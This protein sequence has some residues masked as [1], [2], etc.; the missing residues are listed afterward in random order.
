VRHA[1]AG[2][3]SRRTSAGEDGWKGRECSAWKPALDTLIARIEAG[4]CRHRINTWDAV[5]EVIGYGCFANGIT[6]MWP[7][8]FRKTNGRAPNRFRYY[9]EPSRLENPHGDLVDEYQEP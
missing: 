4:A 3:C 8:K 6:T 5:R 9:S 7:V 1:G 2:G